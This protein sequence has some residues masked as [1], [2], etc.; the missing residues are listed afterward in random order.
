ML[1]IRLTVCYRM[2]KRQHR[3]TFQIQVFLRN[4]WSMTP[5]DADPQISRNNCCF[6][7]LE[8]STCLNL[9][10][11]SRTQVNAY[12]GASLQK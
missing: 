8:D 10:H 12:M 5:C 2:Y 11:A 3:K 4:D 9:P 7:S 1:M 6:E